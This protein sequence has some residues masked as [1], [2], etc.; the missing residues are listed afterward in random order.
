M[1]AKKNGNGFK[2]QAPIIMGFRTSA[3]KTGYRVVNAKGKTVGADIRYTEIK[4][5]GHGFSGECTPSIDE[6]CN[7][8]AQFVIERLTR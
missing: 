2:T 4:N 6:I 3:E 8:A 5:G 1:G 7:M